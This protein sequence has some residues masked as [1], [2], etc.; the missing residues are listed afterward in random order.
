MSHYAPVPTL[1]A[2]PT[3]ITAGDSYA[4]TLSLTEYPAPTWTASL[5]LAGAA[6]LAVTSTA[7]GTSHALTLTAAQTATLSAGAYQYR[8]RVAAGS[9]VTTVDTGVLTVAADIGALAAGEGVSYWQQ[10]KDCAQTALTTIMAGGAVQMVTVMGRQTMFRSP[11]DCL[12]VIAVCDQH[13]AA[14]QR[15]SAFGRVSVAFVR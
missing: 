9:T 8:V 12:K 1:T 13:L 2:V 4:I 15:G 3:T 11:A 10:L 7:S 6:T 5:A 14:A